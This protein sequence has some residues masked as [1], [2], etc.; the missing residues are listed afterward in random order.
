MEI[1]TTIEVQWNDISVYDGT[2]HSKLAF[3]QTKGSLAR[4]MPEY[5][6]I[7]HPHTFL[8]DASDQAAEHPNSETPPR[9]YYIP[10]SLIKKIE[11]L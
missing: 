5:L 1:G 2:P 6:I 10:K 8:T 3:A 11:I 9:Y 7:A 4:E